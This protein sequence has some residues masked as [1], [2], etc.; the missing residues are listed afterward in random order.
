MWK[1]KHEFILFV[2]LAF[3][4]C[5]RCWSAHAGW[6]EV[7]AVEGHFFDHRAH[8]W[9]Y[10]AAFRTYLPPAAFSSMWKRMCA[11]SRSLLFSNVNQITYVVLVSKLTSDQDLKCLFPSQNKPCKIAF[12]LN[13]HFQHWVSLSRN[14]QDKY[15]AFDSFPASPCDGGKENSFPPARD[16]LLHWPP[17]IQEPG[18]EEQ[19]LVTQYLLLLKLAY[20]WSLCH[21]L[22]A[23]LLRDTMIL[24]IVWQRCASVA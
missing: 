2:K 12:I 16:P 21:L 20:F 14:P 5:V 13:A 18:V 9:E 4:N 11:C 19:V 1:I 17:S 7:S 24:F 22:L 8:V 10:T 23:S 3:F 15:N 6:P